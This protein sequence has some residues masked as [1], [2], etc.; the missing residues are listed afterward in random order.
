VPPPPDEPPVVVAF[1]V[2]VEAEE[3]EEAD[4]AAASA[5]GAGTDGGVGA[6]GDGGVGPAQKSVPLPPSRGDAARAAATAPQARHCTV[7]PKSRQ[8]I[9]KSK[10]CIKG[11]FWQGTRDPYLQ[12]MRLDVCRSCVFQLFTVACQL[13]PVLFLVPPQAVV[14]DDHGSGG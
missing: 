3:E 1:Q 7:V 14:G 8:G 9:T 13:N 11:R 5:A 10:H 4:D 12:H 6:V 2:E